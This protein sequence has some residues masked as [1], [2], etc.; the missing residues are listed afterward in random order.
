MALASL[1]GVRHRLYVDGA[2]TL[3]YRRPMSPLWV[4]TRDGIGAILQAQSPTVASISVSDAVAGQLFASVLTD[5]AGVFASGEGAYEALAPEDAESIALMFEP[6]RQVVRPHDLTNVRDVVDLGSEAIDGRIARHVQATLTPDYGRALATALAPTSGGT[7]Q[8]LDIAQALDYAPGRLDVWITQDGSLVREAVSAQ[9]TVVQSK[10]GAMSNVFGRTLG[11]A[12]I[13]FEATF[14]P[15]DVGGPIAISAPDVA[16]SPQVAPG[17]V[18]AL[19]LL[20]TADDA[21]NTYAK[22]RGSYAGMTITA[23][24]RIEPSIAWT[25]RQALATKHQ[26]RVRV[27][28]PRRVVLTTRAPTGRSYMLSQPLNGTPR[29]TCAF[30]G[31]SCAVGQLARFTAE[32]RARLAH[33]RRRQVPRS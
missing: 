8:D 26:V 1:D 4:Q 22:V 31:K 21:A 25:R 33:A 12:S 29:L 15:F 13:A 32:V 30:R 20:L 28:S 23:L 19:T 27:M 17:D 11:G 10:L 24:K 6:R 18:L 9:A 3:R 2:I 5:G 14:R 7:S 16:P